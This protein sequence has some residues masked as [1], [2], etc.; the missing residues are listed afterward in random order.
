MGKGRPRA[1]EKG[2]PGHCSGASPSGTTL[3]NIPQ[4][5]VYYPTEEE[6]KDP[7]EFIDKIRA[8]AESFG[9][10]RIV[11]PKSWKPPFALNPDSFT[12][13]TKSQA[14]HRL[15]VRPA[16]CDPDTFELEYNRFLEDH[17]GRKPK[18]R[19]AVVF[20]GE[21]LDLCRLF[22]AVKRF[23]GHE[24]V[25]KEKKWADVFRFVRSEGKKITECAKHV[26][27]GLYREHLYDYEVYHTRLDR[28]IKAKKCKR[29][30]D[31]KNG[32][33]LG[34][35][36]KRRRK[37]VQG[38]KVKEEEL[39]Q[40]CEQCRSGLHGD[41]M[42]LCDR[43]NK[44]W[45]LYC[46][47]PPLERVPSGNWYCLECVNS[48]KDSFGFVPGKRFSLEAFRKM[49]DRAKRKQFGAVASPSRPQIEKRFWE[50]VE[51]SAGKVD[52][53]YGSDLDTSLYGSGFPRAND[54][55]PA[56]I[57][58]EVWNK[59]LRSPWNLN[60]LPKLPGSILREIHDNI[61]GVMVPWLYV[62]MLFSSFC[63]HFEDHC[64]YSMNYLH[65]YALNHICF[66]MNFLL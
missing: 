39:D 48:D 40:I 51:G 49:A 4:A 60:N 17:C 31:R 58:P 8:E 47:S 36:F 55:L 24:K 52:V 12:F 14:I 25:V 1:V 22:N 65:W 23:G 44:G 20:E 64:F 2:V 26:L 16:P 42:L 37:N 61:A 29:R 6:F 13:P 27:C 32:E 19:A 34:S 21:E 35:E 62:G 54:L 10:C 53:M 66:F 18:K 7:L 56:S 50:I 43:C 28:G 45:H 11:P 46:L 57:E 38:E 63:W 15:Q 5:P 33:A 41:V 9:I 30:G 59:Y 3:L